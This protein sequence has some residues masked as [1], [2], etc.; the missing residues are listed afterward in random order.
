MNW[1]RS[2]NTRRVVKTVALAA[3]VFLAA[4]RVRAQQTADEL[5]QKA[6]EAA[7]KDQFEEACDLLRQLAKTKPDYRN[8]D[9]LLNS[10]C[11]SAQSQ[12]AYEEKLY[13]QGVDLYKQQNY[14]G[15][16]GKFDQAQKVEMWLKRPAHRDEVAGYLKDLAVKLTPANPQPKVPSNPKPKPEPKVTPNKPEPNAANLPD[17]EE[18]TLRSGLHAY[19]DGDFAGAEQKLTGYIDKKGKRQGLAYFFRGAA[20]CTE[21][22]LAGE[23]DDNQKVNAMTDFR[24]AKK[25]SQEF[26]PPRQYVSPKILALYTDAVG[27]GN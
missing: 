10:D 24:S 11:N 21:Y 25:S 1:C 6:G 13:Q 5:Y 12:H 8:S 7:D 22:Y 18:A 14:E 20:Y 4:A 3:A 19:F 2:T 23:K 9:A 26:Q 16:K 17:S 27:A 15:A